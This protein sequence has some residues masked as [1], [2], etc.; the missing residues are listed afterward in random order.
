MPVSARD[1]ADEIRRRQPSIGIVKLHKLLY[2]VQGWHLA[3]TGKP[4]FNEHVEAWVNGP[5]VAEL[6]KDEKHD[7]PRPQQHDLDGDALAA[8]EFVLSRYGRFSGKDLIRLTHNEDPWREVSESDDPWVAIDPSIQQEALK[9]WFQSD[10][11]YVEYAME[12]K[13]H[14]D[15]SDVFMPGPVKMTPDLSASIERARSGERVRHSRPA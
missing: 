5:V 11:E 3:F 1:I 6:W 9:R 15:R 14:R 8:I 13:R 2:Y 4:A 12:L 7:R 10:D